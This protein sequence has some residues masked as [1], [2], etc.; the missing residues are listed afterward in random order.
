MANAIILKLYNG[1]ISPKAYSASVLMDRFFSNMKGGLSALQ[2]GFL[3]AL[4]FMRY[5]HINFQ[6]PKK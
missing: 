3:T 6:F 5:A 2:Y 4:S 1:D